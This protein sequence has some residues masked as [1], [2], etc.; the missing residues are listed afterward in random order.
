MPFAATRMDLKIIMLSDIHQRQIPYDITYMW[1]LKKVTQMNL[2]AKQKQTHKHRE[3]SVVA[4]GKWGRDEWIEN[5]RSAD[6]NY[7]TENA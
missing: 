5:L 6:A 7:Y 3:Q 1:N 2:S 4:R